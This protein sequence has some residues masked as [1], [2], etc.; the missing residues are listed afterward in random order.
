MSR[1]RENIIAVL[2]IIFML[3]LFNGCAAHHVPASHYCKY[4]R[5]ATEIAQDD[6]SNDHGYIVQEPEKCMPG[7][8]VKDA[9]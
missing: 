3:V 2:W 9:K 7:W 4:P 8:E 5:T 6:D 1:A